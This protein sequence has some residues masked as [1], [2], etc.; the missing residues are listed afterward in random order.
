MAAGNLTALLRAVCAS[1][2]PV[3]RLE[4]ADRTGISRAT[5]YRTVDELLA[6]GLVSEIDVPVASGR[7]RPPTVLIPGNAVA[8]LGLQIDVDFAAA[9]IM[10]L[11]GRL[12]S[13]L[14]EHGEF[15]GADVR[16][17]A[18][19]L[20]RLMRA[21]IRNVSDRIWVCG[22]ALA[23][24]GVV[25]ARTGAL[26]TSPNLG[27]SDIRPESLF[28][29]RSLPD[30][31]VRL[32]N[33]ADLAALS[34]AFPAP[35]RIGMST[36]FIYVSGGIGVGG[37]H[38]V[39]GRVLSGG[40]GR[41]GEIGHVCVDPTGPA[42]ACGSTGCLEQY[43]G[44]PALAAAA[45]LPETATAATLAAAA[46]G[47]ADAAVRAVTHAAQALGIALSSAINL[48]DIQTIVLGGSFAELAD[49]LIPDMEKTLQ[50]RVMTARWSPITVQR[51]P[52][53]VAAGATGAALSVLTEVLA[54]PSPWLAPASRGA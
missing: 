15:A 8:G 33:E 28:R 25:D 36:D 54:D 52:E 14:V 29:G 49:L 27:W 42:C 5:T 37:A 23:V 10:D 20:R 11:R 12:L 1:S 41:G 38:L 47:G 40:R 24:P 7:G 22:A 45:E 44:W 43:V 32:G 50:S 35:G 6:A 2:D 9:R 18:S 26:L 31:S 17:A 39:D 30:I 19:A 21:A 46:S 34:V 48:M 4:L 3:S 51:A 13:E 53:I 16:P